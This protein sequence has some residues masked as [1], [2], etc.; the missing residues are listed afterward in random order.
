M[1]NV[2]LIAIAAAVLFQSAVRVTG[3]DRFVNESGRKIPVAHS[4]DVVVVGGSTGAVSAA[5]AAAESG[6]S[7]FL[8]APRPYLGDDMTATLRLW[9]EGDEQAHAPLAKALFNDPQPR[10]GQPS[11]HRMLFS[12]SAD[13]PSA[14]IHADTKTPS[15]LS[16]LRWGDATRQSVQYDK[17][18]NITI[19]LGKA[20]DVAGVHVWAYGRRGS[21]GFGIRDVTV[22]T[23]SDQATW[24]EVGTVKPTPN[25]QIGDTIENLIT[26]LSAR[27]QYLKLAI[28]KDP[29]T[30]RIL[31]AEIEVIR[32]SSDGAE[33][34]LP[35]PPLA[36]P[37]AREANSRSGTS[38]WAREVPLQLLRH[39]RPYRWRWPPLR[40]R[41]G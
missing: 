7:V 27:T 10:I 6:A 20:R 18:V 32:P 11:A 21:T 14:A 34:A 15:R 4:V 37:H 8:A 39:R 9:L 30:A 41:H 23:S 26:R 5:V 38:R 2:L 40:N 28:R 35:L 3:D 13:Q 19:D 16:D 29:K 22:F 36:A 17:D 24:Q 31:L 12:Y 1:R 25:E 33:E